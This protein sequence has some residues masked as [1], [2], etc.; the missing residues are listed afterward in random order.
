MAHVG[1]GSQK[2]SGYEN[3]KAPWI[4]I[5]FFS[6]PSEFSECFIVSHAANSKSGNKMLSE[7][8]LR[9]KRINKNSILLEVQKYISAFCGCFEFFHLSKFGNVLR[10]F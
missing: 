5:R 4:L 8:R 3:A 6:S 1:V 10:E 9:E 2:K 7:I